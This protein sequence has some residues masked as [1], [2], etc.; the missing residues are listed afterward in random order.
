LKILH[1]TPFVVPDPKLGGMPRSVLSLCVALRDRGHQVT[2]WAG[3]DGDSRYR[4]TDHGE[5]STVSIKLFRSRW[6]RLGSVLNTPILPE[7]T[8]PDPHV[9]QSFDVVHMH[10]YWNTFT[11][12]IALACRK[13]SVPLVLQPRGSLVS[14]GQRGVPKRVFQFLFRDQ[15]VR[16]TSIAVA[17]TENERGDLRKSG[18]RNS[19]IQLIPNFAPSPPT[20]LPSASAAKRSFRIPEG[21]KVVLFLGRLHPAKGGKE[22]LMAYILARQHIPESVLLFCGPDEGALQELKRI[23]A[24]SG[25]EETIRFLGPLD[26]DRK[27]LALRAADLYCL[28]SFFEAFPRVVLEAGII[29]TPTILSSLVTLPFAAQEGAVMRSDPEPGA[30][31]RCITAVLSNEGLRLE[32][33]SR[34]RAWVE[35]HFSAPVVIPLVED[36]YAHAMHVTAS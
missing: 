14:S 15:V 17:L 18:F 7:L 19:Q 28:P 32:L 30:L 4:T 5:G 13:G 34:I 22:L 27:W 35:R 8:F 1:V 20:S 10:G 33:S 11:P 23:T 2:I 25:L 31:S 29:G 16:S 3:D 6:R 21:A 36:A 9:L 12:S 26:E 24:A